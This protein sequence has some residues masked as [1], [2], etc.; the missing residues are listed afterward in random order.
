MKKT[1]ILF[2]M[3][4]VSI[5]QLNAQFSIGVTGGIN[6]SKTRF[7]NF[8]H[9]NSE[10]V[11]YYFA[12]IVPG[13]QLSE[14]VS[15]FTDVQFSQKGYKDAGLNAVGIQGRFTYLDVL[16]QIEYRLLQNIS[17]GAGFNIG[18]KIGEDFK[19]E[20]EPWY[21]NENIEITKSTDFGF[22][23]SLKYHIDKFHLLG[24]INYGLA[25][26]SELTFTDVNGQTLD[27]TKMKNTNIQVGMGYTFN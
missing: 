10:S 25:N 22:V 12:G 5:V 4:S 11:L 13:Y 26:I 24:R 2:L 21:T 3:I 6:L 7:I 8:E 19:A 1:A 27:D 16:P 18:F 9:F 17:V 15:L 14:K 23:A 20:H